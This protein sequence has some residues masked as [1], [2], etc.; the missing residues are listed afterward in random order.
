MEI[1]KSIQVGGHTYKVMFVDGLW[2]REGNIGQAH[3]N[4]EQAIEIEPNLHPEQISC[5]F[6]HEVTHA[7]NRIYNNNQLGEADVNAISEGIFQVLN[8]MGIT[9]TKSDKEPI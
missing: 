7:I 4:T 8:D 5:S 6:W 3:H 9:F 2:M 1:P